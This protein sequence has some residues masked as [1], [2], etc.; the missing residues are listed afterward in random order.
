MYVPWFEIHC[1]SMILISKF[2]SYICALRKLMFEGLVIPARFD[3][4]FNLLYFQ[5]ALL[6][7]TV[8]SICHIWPEV[9]SLWVEEL[10]FNI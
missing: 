6:L 10:Y 4:H 7:K 8:L 5:K 3:A 9:N 2:K 1:T